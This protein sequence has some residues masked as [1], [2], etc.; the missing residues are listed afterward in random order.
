MDWKKTK[1]T[2]IHKSG[3]VSILDNYRPIS[4]PP[5]SSKITERAIHRQIVTY[6]D[7]NSLLS[8]FQF[9]LR[10]RLLTELAATHLLDVIR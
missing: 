9:R 6:L 7:Q 3:S 4:I 5:I 1:T 10:P 2:P 8:Y